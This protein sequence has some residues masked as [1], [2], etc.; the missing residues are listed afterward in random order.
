M[1]KIK[2]RIVTTDDG[3]KFVK[4]ENLLQCAYC[5]FL[6]PSSVVGWIRDEKGFVT[7]MTL[8]NFEEQHDDKCINK[9]R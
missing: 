2:A 9:S 3:R 8:E 1:I 6:Q 5:V 7:H 4:Q